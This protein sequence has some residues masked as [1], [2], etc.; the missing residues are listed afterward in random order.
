MLLSDAAA[1]TDGDDGGDNDHDDDNS[2]FLS[3][4]SV[5]ETEE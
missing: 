4:L 2:C 1:S 5:N 3:F